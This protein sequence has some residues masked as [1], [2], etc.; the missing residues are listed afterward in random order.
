MTVLR[1]RSRMISFRLSQQEYEGLLALCSLRGARSLSDLARDAM[2]VLLRDGRGDELP[3]L[4]QQLRKRIDDL[5]REVKQLAQLL[6]EQKSAKAV[7][8]Y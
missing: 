5:D 8:S 4:V 1:R 3:S 7:G 2:Q 6:A